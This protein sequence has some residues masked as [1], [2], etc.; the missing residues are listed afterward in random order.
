MHSPSISNILTYKKNFEQARPFVISLYLSRGARVEL[1][2]IEKRIRK[3][4]VDFAEC[5]FAVGE[6][7]S[8]F[9]ALVCNTF[10]AMTR[11]CDVDVNENRFPN[12]LLVH[13]NR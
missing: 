2:A 11:E 10:A 5:G 12:L 3:C 8:P 13:R 6:L 7:V 4:N 1:S 9:R